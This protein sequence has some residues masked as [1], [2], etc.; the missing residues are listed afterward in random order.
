MSCA[1][2]SDEEMERL[3]GQLND[4]LQVEK[5]L[6]DWELDFLDGSRGLTKWNGNFSIK[7]SHR[8]DKIYRKF[9]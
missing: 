5:G 4:L 7:Q 8:L 9:C 3:L 6:S 1:F 2:V